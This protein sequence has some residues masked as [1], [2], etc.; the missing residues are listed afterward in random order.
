[1]LITRESDYALRIL[2]ALSS[3]EQFTTEEL[4]TKE[5]TPQQFGYKILKKLS[6][7]GPITITRGN[8]GGC[9]LCC[10]LK[11]VSLYDLLKIM[12]ED[13]R[14]SAC[15]SSDFTCL[16]RQGNSNYCTIH[17]NLSIIQE[18]INHEL[19]RHSLY[20]ILGHILTQETL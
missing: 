14:V 8:G 3:G 16:R 1:M 13:Y 15:M 2:S 6:K 4:C 9:R 5:Y 19:Q 7:G 11:Q 17:D 18:A 12:D 10:D 20:E